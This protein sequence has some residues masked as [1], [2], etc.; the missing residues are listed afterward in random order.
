[1][2]TRYR[3]HWSP[4]I[5]VPRSTPPLTDSQSGEGERG[6]CCPQNYSST[7][8]D[9]KK[10]HYTCKV[11][12]ISNRRFKIQIVVSCL[13]WV[14]LTTNGKKLLVV[15][16]HCNR[17]CY[18]PQTKLRKGNVFTHVYHSV[19]GGSAFPQCHEADRPPPPPHQKAENPR[20]CPPPH[21]VNR[22]VYAPYRNPCLLRMLDRKFS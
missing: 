6:T 19:H 15:S 5:L 18:S 7:R 9:W 14:P 12:K 4:P 11:K 3:F 16:T 1:M 22:R 10:V 8:I 13:H 2:A 21:T 20:P 17:N